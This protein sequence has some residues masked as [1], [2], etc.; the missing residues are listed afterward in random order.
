M[1]QGISSAFSFLVNRLEALIPKTD[2]SQGFVCVD[3]A[4][5]MELLTDR[6]PNTLRLFELRTTTFPHDD[7]QAGITGR[8][9]LTA[10]LR[11]RYDIPRDV[12]LLERIVGEDSS[13][14]VNSLRDPAY[15]LATTGITSLITGEATTTPLLDESGNPAALLLI[16]PFD[17]LFSE[18]F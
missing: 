17:L 15:S 9:R 14:L 11:V 4:S 18:A 3:P 12:G 13:Q 6:R 7:G 10:E 1:S 5:G 8:K 2:E 16:V